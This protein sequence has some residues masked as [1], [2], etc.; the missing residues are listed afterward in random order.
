METREADAIANKHDY[1]NACIYIKQ[2]EAINLPQLYRALK[3]YLSFLILP[4][5]EH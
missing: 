1:A 4:E 5:A 2:V 3:S